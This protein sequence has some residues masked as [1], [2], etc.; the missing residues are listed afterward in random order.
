MALTPCHRKRAFA[1]S[2]GYTVAVDYDFTACF[3]AIDHAELARRLTAHLNDDE[4]TQRVMTAVRDQ[5]PS[6]SH[7]LR[8]DTPLTG[9]LVRLML[10]HVID[11]SPPPAVG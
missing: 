8:T 4:A 9:M 7:G 1:R 6:A 10:D 5:A 3:A 11:W 2:D